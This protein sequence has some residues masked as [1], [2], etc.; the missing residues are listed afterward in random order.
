[1]IR[2]LGPFSKPEQRAITDAIESYK[3]VR[4]SPRLKPG[5]SHA[6]PSRS[7]DFISNMA[8]RMNKLSRSYIT[9]R[10]GGSEKLIR[11][12]GSMSVSGG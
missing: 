1:M 7:V 9:S 12:S 8:K 11:N 10:K 4:P 2:K 6:D 5:L 3:R